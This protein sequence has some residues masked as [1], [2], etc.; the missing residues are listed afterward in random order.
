MHD[1]L[2][3]DVDTRGSGALSGA[4][5]DVTVTVDVDAGTAPRLATAVDTQVVSLIRTASAS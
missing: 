4:D 3:V 5:D 2:V 1:A